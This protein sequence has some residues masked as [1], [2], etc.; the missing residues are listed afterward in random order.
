MTLHFGAEYKCPGSDS[1]HAIYLEVG[2]TEKSENFFIG[3]I[4]DNDIDSDI[5]FD[6]EIIP[7]TLNYKYESTLAGNLNWYVGKYIF[8][9]DPDFF[10]G[11]TVEDDFTPDGDIHFELGVRFNF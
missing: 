2:Y 6:V 7:I 9:D 8:M 1:S 5:D 11:S 3:N 4:Q 10:V